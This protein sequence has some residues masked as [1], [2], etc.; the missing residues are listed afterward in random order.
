MVLQIPDGY[1]MS[2]LSNP[3]PAEWVL[4]TD[5]L[6]VPGHE[7]YLLVVEHD[8]PKAPVVVAGTPWEASIQAVTCPELE[9]R[10]VVQSTVRE[11]GHRE[12]EGSPV[13]PEPE[14]GAFLMRCNLCP[15]TTEDPSL[16][17]DHMGT[18]RYKFF[19]CDQCPEAFSKKSN[20]SKHMSIHTGDGKKTFKCD[21]CSYS[22]M[23]EYI[24]ER[25]M[26]TEH[27]ELC[28]VYV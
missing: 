11:H 24:L 1:G 20:L 22:T 3:P 7:E 16:M 23:R 19:K 21:K 12:N 5:V 17:H 10:C 28:L 26:L 6:Q 9:N 18:H 8:E 14:D 2:A 13:H 27:T 4:N 25:H 15:Y